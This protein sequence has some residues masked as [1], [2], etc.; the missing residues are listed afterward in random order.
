[1]NRRR[2][3]RRLLAGSRNVAFADFTNLVEGFGFQ[4]TRT[5]GS[6]HI[7][8]HPRSRR[9]LNLQPQGGQAKAYQVRQFLD[10]IEEYQ[11]ELEAET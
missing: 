7:F 10:M 9:R 3:L 11:L 5:R 2:L 1:V 4:Q 8:W 6:H